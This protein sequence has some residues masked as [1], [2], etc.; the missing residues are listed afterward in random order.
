MTNTATVQAIYEAFGKGDVPAILEQLAEDVAWEHWLGG[1]SA[2]DAGIAYLTP[3]SG[4]DG[5]A[6]FFAALHGLE[7]HGFEPH[8]FLADDRYGR[9]ADPA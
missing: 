4:R 2:A 5:V 9:G 3:R 6:Q 7:F 8:A 1:N